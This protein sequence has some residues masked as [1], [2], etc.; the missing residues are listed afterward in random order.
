MSGGKGRLSGCGSP[1]SSSEKVELPGEYLDH[2]P[3]EVPADGLDLTTSSVDML[4][5]LFLGCCAMTDTDINKEIAMAS[6]S[7]R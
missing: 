5:V 3:E 2:P 1:G 7:R 6:A 4:G